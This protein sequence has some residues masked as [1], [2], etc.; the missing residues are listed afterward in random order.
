MV[1]HCSI[2]QRM[3]SARRGAARLVRIL[4]FRS[5]GEYGVEDDD[6]GGHVGRVGERVYIQR[7]RDLACPGGIWFGAFDVSGYYCFEVC[8]IIE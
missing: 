8:E 3:A 1:C 2:C 6:I 5:C 7:R 4:G